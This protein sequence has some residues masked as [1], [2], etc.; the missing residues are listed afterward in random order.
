MKLAIIGSREFKDSKLARQIFFSYFATNQVYEI[1]SG[2]AKGADTCARIIAKKFGVKL[3]EFLP[4]WDK[5]GK[6][7]GMIRNKDIINS[8]DFV[9]AFWNGK[10]KG[11]ANSLN[12]AKNSKKPT[13]VIYF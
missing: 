4:D 1:I 9:L 2:G 8:A 12:L 6:S 13:L 11:T 7:A 5:Y 3:T 10:S